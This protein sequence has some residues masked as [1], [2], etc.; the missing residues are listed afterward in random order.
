[1]LRLQIGSMLKFNQRFSVHCIDLN[2]GCQAIRSFH[3]ASLGPADFKVCPFD[4]LNA[5]TPV[6]AELATRPDQRIAPR[7]L[8][9]KI[10]VNIRAV[11]EILHPA[12]KLSIVGIFCRGLNH[13]C[14]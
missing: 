9:D 4:S 6:E 12:L 8:V 1:M 3:L 2:Y 7:L 11:Y 5:P 14:R 10:G 13:D